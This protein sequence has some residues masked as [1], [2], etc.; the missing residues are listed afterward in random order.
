MGSL[1]L[2]PIG[3]IRK[4]FNLTAMV[5]TGSEGG[6]GIGIG[7]R[8]GYEKIIS[9][10]IIEERYEQAS[11]LFENDNRVKVFFGD[12][13]IVLPEMLK[14]VEED[15]ILF[16]LDAHLP[17]YS[18]LK[19]DRKFTMGEILPLR[20]EFDIILKN[21]DCSSDVIIIDD[22]CL[23]DRLYREKGFDL[24][25]F[26]ELEEQRSIP[27]NKIVSLF[28]DHNWEIINKAEKYLVL[29]P[30]NRR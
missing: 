21:R 6:F 7:L 2:I 16:W 9:C 28:P 12:S 8:A 5:E 25:F 13:R 30:K 20:D 29:T 24:E 14:E 23:Y 11:K 22:L 17:N 26:M 15:N 10:D 19:G 1:S 18:P 3:A 27:I 4:T